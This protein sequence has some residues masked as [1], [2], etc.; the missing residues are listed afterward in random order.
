M[1]VA[2]RLEELTKTYACQLV[3]SEEVAALA[4]IDVS[5]FPRHEL[6]LRNRLQ[7]LAVRVI[8]DVGRL[9]GLTSQSDARA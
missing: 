9:A 8:E 5:E 1:H 3:I 7:P 6:T 2:S 4:G